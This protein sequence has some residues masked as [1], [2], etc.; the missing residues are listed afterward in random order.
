MRCVLITGMSAVGKSTVI[1]EL[2]RRGYRAVDL[3][4]PAWSRYGRLDQ[5]GDSDIDWLWREDRV[6]ELLSSETGGVLFVAGCAANQGAFHSRFDRIVLLTASEEVTLDRLASRST[7]SFGKDPAERTKI[8]SD[9]ANFEPQLRATADV[10][11]DTDTPLETVVDALVALG[12]SPPSQP[13]G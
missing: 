13:I 1:A 5:S 3:D 12:L 8:L 4:D 7:N 2:T 9:K 10:I 11:I 6:D